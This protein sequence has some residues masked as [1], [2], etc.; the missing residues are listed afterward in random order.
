MPSL[1][2]LFQN[3]DILITVPDFETS[4]LNPSEISL[5]SLNGVS[6]KQQQI[7]VSKQQTSE[8][9]TNNSSKTRKKM[10]KVRTHEKNEQKETV[11]M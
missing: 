2:M 4:I 11:L 8:T 10:P 1:L 9:K 6:N 5:A 3:P 7:D